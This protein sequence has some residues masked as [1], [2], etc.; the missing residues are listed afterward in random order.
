MKK[1]TNT[2]SN[3]KRGK[4]VRPKYMGDY[5]CW[6]TMKKMPYSQAFLEILAE[7]LIKYANEESSISMGK[8]YQRTGISK[9]SFENFLTRS[10]NLADAYTHALEVMGFRR[11]DGT[12]VRKYDTNAVWRMQYQYGSWWKNAGEYQAALAK[13]DQQSERDVNINVN[14]SEVRS[15]DKYFK[16]E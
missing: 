12:V 16:K 9:G 4:G 13:K 2:K 5:S 3:A 7:E 11:D 8:F 15:D 1:S 14:M 6:K 10:Q